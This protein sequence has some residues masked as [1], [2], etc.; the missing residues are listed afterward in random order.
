MNSSTWNGIL[1]LYILL[2]TALLCFGYSRPVK[3]EFFQ[4]LQAYEKE[5]YST[6]YTGFS[7]LIELGNAEAAFNL[8]VMYYHGHGI[9]ANPIESMAY[10]HLA[11]SLGNKDAA[12]IQQQISAQLSESER[13]L[14]RLRFEELRQ[15]V[16][17][18]DDAEATQ[19]YDVVDLQAL[20]TP[21]PVFSD[22]V[23]RRSHFG[24]IVIR[25]LVD[26]DGSVPVVDVI[27]S[28]PAGI[29]ERDTLRALRRWKFEPTGKQHLVS[30]QL[31]FWVPGSLR[32]RE[33]QQFLERDQIWD[34]AALGISAYQEYIGSVLHLVHIASGKHTFIDE[35]LPDEWDLPD[36]TELLGSRS[37]SFRYRSFLGYTLVQVEDGVIQ[38]VLADHALEAPDASELIGKRIRGATSGHY[39]ISRP[40]RRDSI[41]VQK[42]YPVPR[43]HTAGY[44]WSE[45]AK[46]GNAK[47]QRI[48]ANQRVDWQFYLLQQNEVTSMAWHGVRL[49]LDGESEQGLALIERAADQGYGVA[50]ELLKVMTG[51]E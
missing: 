50:E 22:D 20:A 36:F 39:T 1:W 43:Q 25:Y 45:A 2:S 16:I 11:H 30:T 29:Y 6:A 41:L 27:D 19:L 23:H 37:L 34:Y 12:T 24:Y 15:Q 18:R 49:T 42:R 17:I 28:Y 14:A 35:S 32:S 44:W 47:A 10:F 38:A 31:N 46:N 3:A 4:A 13:R 9:E 40:S 5:S 21:M 33:A 48:L 7:A 8:G 51:S 26:K